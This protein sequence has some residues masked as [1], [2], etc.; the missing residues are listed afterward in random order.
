[1][2]APHFAKWDPEKSPNTFIVNS[3]WPSDA[4]YVNIG[5]G[6]GLLP[7]STKPLPDPML[8]YYQ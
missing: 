4:I 6:N 2:I 1:M 7:D 8:T 3:L 5:S